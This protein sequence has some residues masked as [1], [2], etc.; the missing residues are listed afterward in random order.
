MLNSLQRDYLQPVR[1]FSRSARLFLAMIIIY[2]V[3]Y[4][5]WQL[6]FNFYILQS[7]FSREFLGLI[8]AMPYAAGLLFGI[9]MGRLSDRI[10]RKASILVGLAAMGVF[11]V[12]QITTRDPAVI[13]GSA[14]VYGVSYMLFVVSQPPL[15]AKLSDAENRTMLFSLS[16]GLQTL[17]GAIGALFAGQLPGL[18]SSLLGVGEH[19]AAAYQA[20]LITSVVVGTSSIIP[21]WMVDETPR[22]V[23]QAAASESA[24]QNQAGTRPKPESAGLPPALLS[25]TLW[26][27]V[28]Q[29][30]IGFGAA[31]LIPYMNV[32][33]KDVFA[34]SDSLLG[35]LFSISALLIGVGSLVA[36]RL[37]T[38]LGG[39]IRAV[40]AT[41]GGSLIFLLLCGFAP[42][43]WLSAL[44]YLIRTALM[45]MASPLYT[46][47][48]MERAPEE[49][50]GFV[51]SLL[52]M[53]WTIGWAI[54]PFVSGVV[55]T[56]YGFKPL[57]IATALL[58]ATASSLIWILFRRADR[59]IVPHPA[60]VP[61][62]I[63]FPE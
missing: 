56:A 36:P 24:S 63:E 42:F 30:V 25:L 27:A 48:C 29:L 1:S 46:A 5:G 50:Q 44:G 16:Y 39:K 6:F 20:V 2:G 53:T 41:Q 18:F 35:V 11:M 52:N 47:F 22:P 4:S 54:G 23:R 60:V 59:P 17:A 34:I 13:V 7:G 37:S 31:I 61:P 14:F 45:N 57:F 43:L 26:M 33:F 8:N 51:S 55:Q 62:T 19:S 3:I 49:H 32:F 38:S 40:V 58:Y 12:I 15:M 28:P 21:M 9:P 10:G